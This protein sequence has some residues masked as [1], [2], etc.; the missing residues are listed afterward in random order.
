MDIQLSALGVSMINT[1]SA[2]A[3]PWDWERAFEAPAAF[4]GTAAF[5]SSV[6]AAVRALIASARIMNVQAVSA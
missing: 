5:V 1:P 4:A 2:S 6:F 3:G